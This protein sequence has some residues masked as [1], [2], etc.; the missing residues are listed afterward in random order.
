[1]T[2]KQLELRIAKLEQQV[3]ELKAMQEPKKNGWRALIGIG[4]DD[5][6]MKEV[7]SYA[8]KYREQDRQKTRR[9]SKRKSRDQ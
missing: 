4:T 1:M 5:P 7:M 6:V 9:Q 3:A 8:V 2:V